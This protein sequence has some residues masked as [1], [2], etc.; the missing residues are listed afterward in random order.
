MT[1]DELNKL[2]ER[3]EDEDDVISIEES[4]RMSCGLIEREKQL[5]EIMQHLRYAM[6]DMQLARKPLSSEYY[7]RV[8][9]EV[10]AKLK[11]MGLEI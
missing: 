8:V 4:H 5:I 11:E 1:N 2:I 3:F 7:L 6:M 9:I 10:N